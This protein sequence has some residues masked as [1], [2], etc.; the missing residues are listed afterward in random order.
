MSTLILKFKYT[1]NFITMKS[2][3]DWNHLINLQVYPLVLKI[4]QLYTKA[5]NM[6]ITDKEY[7]IIKVLC[8][9]NNGKIF[10]QVV[11]II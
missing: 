5:I 1:I 3:K 11:I 4:A 6:E 7:A 10:Y 2:L 9:V 8:V